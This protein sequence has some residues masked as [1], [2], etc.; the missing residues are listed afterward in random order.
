MTVLVMAAVYSWSADAQQ[1]ESPKSSQARGDRNITPA[2]NIQH[3][4]PVE[5]FRGLLGMTPAQREKALAGK[6]P[7]EK[8]AILGKVKEYEALPQEVRDARLRQTELHWDLMRLM[9]LDPAERAGQLKQISP[10]FQPMIMDQLQQLSHVQHCYQ[11]DLVQI[12]C[13]SQAS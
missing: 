10:L 8:K 3:I 9:R 1:S 5:Y 2:I 4:T 11:I 12:F 6:S 13:N 7:Q